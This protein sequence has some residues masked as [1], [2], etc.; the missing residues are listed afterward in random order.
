MTRLTILGSG[1]SHGI[2]MIGCDCPVCTSADPRDRRS[3]TSA[4]FSF[5]ER[6]V[7]IDTGPEL[8]IQCIACDVRRVDAILY[9]HHH[10][11]HVVGLDDVRRFNWLGKG[12]VPVYANEATLT[13]LRTMFRYAFEHDPDYPSAKPELT[14]HAIRG[15]FELF[16][17]TVKPLAY[18]HGPLQVLGFRIGGIAYCPDCSRIPDEVR[19]LLADLDV[20]VLDALRRRPHP[21]HFTLEQ[22]VEEAR[23]I[24]A[25]QTYFT[26]IAHEL[27]HEATNATLPAGMAL[28]HDGLV[29]EGA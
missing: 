19:P 15:P 27:G 29:V 1:T 17:R 21:T 26:H 24:G 8:R 2:P 18:W 11:D 6:H 14:P 23:R 5:D 4:L 22:A 25:K 16:G 9:T 7:L 12:A 10:A 20:L 13:H 28:A 3:R